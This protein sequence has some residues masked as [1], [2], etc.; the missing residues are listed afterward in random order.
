MTNKTKLLIM[1]VVLFSALCLYI[2]L[3][4]MVYVWT[5]YL[6]ATIQKYLPVS[7]NYLD[8]TLDAFKTLLVLSQDDTITAMIRLYIDHIIGTISLLTLVLMCLIIIRPKKILI[9]DSTENR[10]YILLMLVYLGWNFYRCFTIYIE[11]SGIHTFVQGSLL[12]YTLYFMYLLLVIILI[13]FCVY[14]STYRFLLALILSIIILE[15]GNLVFVSSYVMILSQKIGL[16]YN[17]KE[18][19]GDTRT[20]TEITSSLIQSYTSVIMCDPEDCEE[21][22]ERMENL[23]KATEFIESLPFDK[24]RGGLEI[25]G[26]FT[27]AVA[28]VIKDC[29][30][31]RAAYQDCLKKYCIKNTMERFRQRAEAEASQKIWEEMK[32]RRG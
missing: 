10:F 23:C 2:T 16:L 20:I 22:R 25:V 30:I 12:A 21:L 3:P 1:P 14:L 18:I 29:G 4:N 27:K 13:S 6:C 7:K 9:E 24:G 31:A 19:F 5:G 32:R 11:Y 28:P 8:N 17:L 26:L 15:I